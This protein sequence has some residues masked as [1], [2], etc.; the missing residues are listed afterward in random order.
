[1]SDSLKI[2]IIHLS[3][4]HKNPKENRENIA[5]LAR[6]AA[7][8]GA[9]IIL[10]PEMSLSGYIFEDREDVLPHLEPKDGPAAKLFGAVAKE[11]GVYLA[12]GVGEI[13]YE[14]DMLYNATFVFDPSGEL[15]LRYRK[16]NA[17]SR[18]ACPGTPQDENLF[19]TPWGK[20]G[21]LI[22][23]DTY[24]SL[25]SRIAALRGASLLLVPANWPPSNLFPENIW[26][27]RAYENGLWLM[28]ANRT[29]SDGDQFHCEKSVSYVMD[30]DGLVF[31]SVTD[32]NS[33]VLLAEIPLSEGKIA[34]QERRKAIL[35]S[36]KPRLYH[37]VHANLAFFKNLTQSFKLSAP[38]HID[39]HFLSPGDKV[40]PA[41]FAL[42]KASSFFYENLV[43]LPLWDYDP[44]DLQKLERIARDI[45]L[46]FLSARENKDGERTTLLINKEGLKEFPMTPDRPEA[47]I[48][49]G[50]LV[51]HPLRAED[52][53]HPELGLSAAKRGADL[54]LAFE[55][56]MTPGDRFSVSMRPVDQLAAA[57]CAQNGSAIG[58]IPDG[59][60]PGRGAFAPAPACL[61][62]SLDTR[63]LRDKHFQD[64]IDFEALFKKEIQGP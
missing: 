45:G 24:H 18:W 40:N 44:S 53:I 15:I 60:V 37:R 19:D 2:A 4:I 17:E 55:K 31:S 64:R 36:R 34:K 11:K 21:V 23:S 9:R 14:T 39:L 59:H 56:E 12:C 25:P 8:K 61:G 1:M 10:A 63:E 49:L 51:I 7:D 28:V 3:V 62:Y 32:P 57:V 43:L 38:G 22:C 16:M 5:R 42:E 41:D 52:L 30:P 47:L 27:F 6:E 13:D 58:L 29:G 20:I 48:T 54:L 35:L 50:P 26:R 46:S 33:A